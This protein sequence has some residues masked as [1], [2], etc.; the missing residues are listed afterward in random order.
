MIQLAVDGVSKSDRLQLD[1]CT[2]S[3]VKTSQNMLY[4]TLRKGVRTAIIRF[5]KI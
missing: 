2:A 5:G 1:H 3:T 4:V